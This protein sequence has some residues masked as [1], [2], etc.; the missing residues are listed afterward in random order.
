MSP[1]LPR[2][3]GRPRALP[4]A[5]WAP[6]CALAEVLHTLPSGF[7]PTRDGVELR[8]LRRIFTAEE[9][10]LASRLRTTFETAATL[11]ARLEEPAPALE[12]QLEAMWG[13]GQIEAE[14]PRGARRFRLIPFIIGIYE[15]QLDRMDRELAELFERYAPVWGGMFMQHEPP[16]FL[17][18]PAQNAP[19]DHH[20]HAL[21][22]HR[23]AAIL[24]AG[25]S[26]AVKHCVCRTE[27]Q[28]V[29]K[30]C[31]HPLETCLAIGHRADAFAESPFSGRVI[32]REEAQAILTAAEEA[33]LVH[34]VHNV[35]RG[36]TFICNCCACSCGMVKAARRYGATQRALNAH[37]FAEV[38]GACVGCG[39]CADERC[40]MGAVTVEQER[41]VVITSRCIGCGLCATACPEQA[42]R[43][44]LRPPQERRAPPADER[45]WMDERAKNRAVSYDAY[46]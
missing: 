17:V 19:G 40:P 37:Y 29:G 44:T 31:D 28:L 39:L 45:A 16:L 13:K 27:R 15:Y 33:G 34:N 2:S 30:G 3:P 24:E 20:H 23:A 38:V 10:Q 46:R 36:H 5:E 35:E 25:L 11:A 21:P 1:P 41:A 6:F 22:V 9:A 14:G 8:L 43:L 26:F 7:P 42:I 18:V 12:A 32:T 4:G